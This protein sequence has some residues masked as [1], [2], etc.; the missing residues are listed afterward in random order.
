[1]QTVWQCGL[2]DGGTN[3]SKKGTES[4]EHEPN[5]LANAGA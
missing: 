5:K 3:N 4:W 2:G 1:V